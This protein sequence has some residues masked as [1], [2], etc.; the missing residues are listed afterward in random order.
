MRDYTPVARALDMPIY[1]A[2]HYAK[3]NDKK[4]ADAYLWKALGY[5][6]KI[7]ENNPNSQAAYVAMGLEVTVFE[8]LGEWQNTLTSIQ[9]IINA[10][11][12]APTLINS[13]RAIEMIAVSR[14]KDPEAAIKIFTDFIEKYPEHKIKPII[15]KEIENIKTK[16]QNNDAD[17]P[18]S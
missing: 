14:L 7:Y 18:K 5:Y 4:S 11:P 6:K 10:Y 17:K 9:Q 8:L 2:G 15:L 12:Y 16:S 13:L 3:N 1:I